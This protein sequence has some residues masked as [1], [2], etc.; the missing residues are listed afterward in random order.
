MSE[1]SSEHVETTDSPE[2]KMEWFQDVDFW[3]GFVGWFLFNSLAW[4]LMEPMGGDL[5]VFF[6]P[7]LMLVNIIALIYFS[8]KNKILSFG[9]LTANALNLV[10]VIIQGAAHKAICFVPFFID[11]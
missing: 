11:F 3:F 10:I 9:I 5:I 7:V 1:K 2:T 6:G 4:F 8:K